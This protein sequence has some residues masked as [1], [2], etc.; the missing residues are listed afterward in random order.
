MRQPLVVLLPLFLT[1][2]LF[3][4]PFARIE[5][6]AELG[7]LAVL[8]HKIQFSENGTYFDYAKSGGQDVLFPVVRLS[9][10][11]VL[12]QRHIVTL[13]YQPLRLET[14]S[15][16]KNEI[17]VDSLAFAGGTPMRYLYNFP[18]YRLSWMY[19]LAKKPGNELAL[20]AG[21]QIRNAT[22][23]FESRD[24]EL[25][26]DN[27]DIGPVP[28]LKFRGRY[29]TTTPVW[30]GTEIDG[31]YAPVSYLNGSDEEIVGAI[32]DA[33]LRAGIPVLAGRGNMFLNIRYLGGGA[34]GTSS[35]NV[36][37]GDGYVKNWLHFLTVSLGASFTL[38]TGG[39][40]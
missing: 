5:A 20:G 37:P 11:L 2:T 6:G 35:E 34:V 39:N 13:L 1:G 4:E 40:G 33:S 15:L 38:R 29:Q 17:I 16:L 14:E 27:R 32:L 26:R 31:F 23:V 18:F 21:L 9:A 30:L 3:G 10:D 28:L 12:K 25:Y 36:W 22:I 19:N 24:G 8:S 7:F